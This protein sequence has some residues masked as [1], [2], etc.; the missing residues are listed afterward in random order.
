MTAYVLVTGSRF[1]P[2][3]GRLLKA[4]DELNAKL[5]DDLMIVHGQC[6]P[7]HPA[8]RSLVHWSRAEHCGIHP[9]RLLGADWQA[10]RW[11]RSTGVPTDPYPADWGRFGRAAGPLR[12][13]RMVD[14][15]SGVRHGLVAAFPSGAS[16]G[17][18]DCVR[19][20]TRAGI[21]VRAYEQGVAL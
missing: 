15:L 17:T 13:Q 11:A 8:S 20:A 5:D 10:D 16:V 21:P 18:M 1:L 3:D 4:L 6:D 9:D 2:A 12:N 19:R 7:R 14:V